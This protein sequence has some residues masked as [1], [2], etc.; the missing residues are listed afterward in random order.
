[1]MYLILLFISNRSNPHYRG[2]LAAQIQHGD[3]GWKM[4]MMK[5]FLRPFL[6]LFQMKIKD[7]RPIRLATVLILFYTVE[8]KNASY[9]Y[10]FESF[11]A[12]YF[13]D[14]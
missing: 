14:V 5:D 10:L 2:L 9:K 11:A 6:F 7:N 3:E 12:I 13:L 4:P 1:M 8:Q